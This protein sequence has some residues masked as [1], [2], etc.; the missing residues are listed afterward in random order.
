MTP[1]T[2]INGQTS[3]RTPDSG[4]NAKSIFASTAGHTPA[5]LGRSSSGVGDRTT[6]GL[7]HYRPSGGFGSY[8]GGSRPGSASSRTSSP[9]PSKQASQLGGTR[10]YG[11]L[12][13]TH[14]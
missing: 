14:F 3:Q 10:L 11:Q 8:G 13:D 6:T 9:G 5:T 7:A 1:T 12:N 2:T 4:V